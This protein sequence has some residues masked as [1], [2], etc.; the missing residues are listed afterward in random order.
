VALPAPTDASTCLVTG[1][2]SGIGTEIARGLAERG[3]GV[4]LVARREERLAELAEE[5]AQSGVR[6]ET[7]AADVSKGHDRNR[8]VGEL[9]ERELTVEVLINNA[10]FGSGGAF[11]ELDGD[12]ETEMVRTNVEA[13]V[14]LSAAYLPQMAERGSGAV[15]NVASLIA[16]QPVPYQ[17]TYGAS[18]AFVLSFTD[19][20]HEELRG[21]GV[22]IT[23]VC[24][25]PVRTEFGASGGFGGADDRIP[26]P[27]WLSA[28]QVARAAL[29]GLE[30][31]D[32]VVVPGPINRVAALSGQHL[33]RSLL[34]P[35][36]R[37]LWPVG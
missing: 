3:H 9:E 11:V 14:G 22:T 21:S 8:L 25:G 6:V 27:L 1:A 19:A 29:E 30:K 35:L 5:L 23:A 37:R 31:G 26:G 32:R 16:F 4:T 34:L 13:V 12:G 10:G 15:L 28:E 2:S 33:P 18:K 24:P 17:A 36:I 20:L 7:L